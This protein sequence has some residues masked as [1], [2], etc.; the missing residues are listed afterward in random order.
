M[1][2]HLFLAVLVLCLT[3]ASQAQRNVDI[4]PISP[5]VLNA[6]V[7]GDIED[8]EDA[9]EQDDTTG[10]NPVNLPGMDLMPKST[11]DFE[12][13]FGSFDVSTRYRTL[14]ITE[15]ANNSTIRI[16]ANNVRIKANVVPPVRQD[17]G[18]T[19]QITLDDQLLIE[20]QTDFLLDD[21]DR[22]PHVIGLKIIDSEGKTVLKAEDVRIVLR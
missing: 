19:L 21:A 6:P 15:P 17:L 16:H 5:P 14:E 12:M 9:P 4:G 7:A 3:C 10:D 22:G 8:T 20:N 13:D 11:M 2:F 1:R 18:H